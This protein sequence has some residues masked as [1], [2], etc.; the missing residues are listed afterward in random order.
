M[1]SPH[2]F[3]EWVKAE[4]IRK[5]EGIRLAGIYEVFSLGSAP[6]TVICENLEWNLEGLTKVTFYE[7]ATNLLN[8]CTSK[9]VEKMVDSGA[10]Q[11]KAVKRGRKIVAY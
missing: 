4:G 9:E 3:E 10:L 2:N 7:P 8:E 5:P 6:R 11:V 1:S